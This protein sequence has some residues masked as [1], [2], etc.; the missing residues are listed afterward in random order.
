MKTLAALLT[1]LLFGAPPVAQAAAT[2][3]AQ[4]DQWHDLLTLSFQWR[5]TPQLWQRLQTLAID[6]EPAVRSQ[7]GQ[8]CRSV[9]VQSTT[10]AHRSTQVMA[11]LAAAGI[12][13]VAFKGIGVMAGLYGKPSDRMVGDVDILIAPEDLAATMDTLI[14]LGFT[15]VLPGDLTDY[16]DY[17][18]YRTRADNLFLVFKDASGFEIDLHWGLKAIAGVEFSVTEI[19]TR[20]ETVTLLN[21]PIRVA[22]PADAML[23]SVHHSVRDD[24]APASAIKDLCDLQAWWNCRDRWSPQ[25]VMQ[26]ATAVGLAHPLLA[27]WQILADLDSAHPVSA[28]VTPLRAS[29]PVREQAIVR[30]LK[31][32]LTLQIA[33]ETINR[34]LIHTLSWQTVKRFITRR[35]QKGKTV[36]FDQALW[37][38][39]HHSHS[40]WSKVC[41]LVQAFLNLNRQKLEAYKA[42]SH[43]QGPASQPDEA[44]KQKH[45]QDTLIL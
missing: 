25:T 11:A 42:L 43:L 5:V 20:A 18:Q 35:F 24:L 29:L 28:E 26:Q 41:Q 19:L 32:L 17:L 34:D 14:P 40:K 12:S 21:R 10:A 9:M 6:L 27:L 33:G 37:G 4:T 38:I 31:T 45:L 1:E 3:V 39:N 22:S 44:K 15:P 16:L 2:A 23:L 7:F 13:A 8:I 36:S 30:H